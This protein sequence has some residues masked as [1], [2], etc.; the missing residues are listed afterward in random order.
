M[1]TA[2]LAIN[3]LLERIGETYNLDEYVIERLEFSYTSHIR[4]VNKKRITMNKTDTIAGQKIN[5]DGVTQSPLTLV[6]LDLHVVP[7]VGDV[8]EEDC[9]CDSNFMLEIIPQIGKQLRETYHWL[10]S[11]TV[12]Y[13][14]L[15]NAGGHGT[16]EAKDQYTA[17]LRNFNIDIIWQ[18][19]QS[20]K[21]DVSDSG[22]WMSM[23]AAV[24][25]VHGL[26]RCNHKALAT[27]VVEAWNN[28]LSKEAFAN[29]HGRLQV[30]MRCILDA[31]GVNDLVESKRG[32]LFCDATI[33]DPKEN[34]VNDVQGLVGRDGVVHELVEIQE[35]D[36]EDDDSD[37]V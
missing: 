21:T 26:W 8:V 22:V 12:I 15:D 28:Y 5:S 32:R 34:E 30:V 20:P 10:P 37:N 3:E 24:Q 17:A 31:K 23:Q 1:C 11:T 36:V 16:N 35:E 13:L 33:L 25:K 14:S 29:V 27:S 19:P 7:R 4:S 2:G 18:I 6:D 9:S